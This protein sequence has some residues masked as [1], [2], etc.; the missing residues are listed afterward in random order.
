M[1]HHSCFIY[2]VTREYVRRPWNTV[3]FAPVWPFLCTAMCSFDRIILLGTNP[4]IHPSMILYSFHAP[5]PCN[6]ILTFW[7]LCSVLQS[8]RNGQRRAP[9]VNGQG[10][11]SSQTSGGRGQG[12][13][14]GQDRNRT[15]ISASDLDAELDKYHAAAAKEE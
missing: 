1:L 14:R 2:L 11:R 6:V 12:R 5:P 9:Q 15:P 7:L 4:S 3:N 13:G 10:G 8:Q